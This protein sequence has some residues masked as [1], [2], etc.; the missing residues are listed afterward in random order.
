MA[1]LPKLGPVLFRK[2]T[3]VGVGLLGGSLGLAL[4]QR[5]LA[6]VVTGCVRRA[7]SLDECLRAGAVD[8][9]T[10]DVQSAVRD[11]DLVILCTPI[12]Q[13]AEL[14]ARFAPALRAGSVVTDVGSAKGS[15]VRAVEP[16]VAA[17]GGRFIGS[18]PMAGTEKTGVRSARADLYQGAVCVITPT[19]GSDPE[20][21]ERIESLW[22]ALGCRI[23][24][25]SPEHHDDLVS[26]S[27]HL[28]QVVAAQLVNSVLSP[29]RPAE[30]AL[31][32]AGGFRDATRTASGSPE[33]WRDIALANRESLCR[34]LDELTGALHATRAL[35]QAGDP[36]ALSAFFAQAKQ[37][38]DAWIGANTSLE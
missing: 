23:L 38:R 22:R 7:A 32:C 33:M 9:A 12:G 2:V 15:V 4:R 5:Q 35:V 20:A 10:L 31:L 8:E 27:S 6:A 28:V 16:L 11:A 13:M 25:V 19:S 14:A 29:A 24:V 30:Q 36:Q 26:R 37:R 17:T 3:L 21:R 18:H 1:W 34:A